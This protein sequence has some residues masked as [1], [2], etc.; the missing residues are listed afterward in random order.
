MVAV[1]NPRLLAIDVQNVET[2]LLPIKFWGKECLSQIYEYRID[3][4]SAHDIDVAL[5]VGKKIKLSVFSS[6]NKEIFQGTIAACVLKTYS[7]QKEGTFIYQLT[8][9]PWLWLLTLQSHCQV[10]QN[11]TVIDIVKSICAHYPETSLD[12]S[13][14][15]KSYPPLEYVVQY[16]ESDYAFIARLLAAY[17]IFFFFISGEEQEVWVLVDNS[18]SLPTL[19]SAVPFQ[20]E[21][22][23]CPHVYS[24]EEQ[25]T[26]FSNTISSQDYNYHEANKVLLATISSVHLSADKPSVNGNQTFEYFYYPGEY[27]TTLEGQK[28]IAQ[29]LHASHALEGEVIKAKSNAVDLRAGTL[30]TLKDTAAHEERYFVMET[31]HHAWDFSYVDS[32][33][34]ETGQGYENHIQ[35]H[36]AFVPFKPLHVSRE[37]EMGVQSAL[38]I[39]TKQNGLSTHG[40][41]EVKVKLCWDNEAS[42]NRSSTCWIRVGQKWAGN[43]YGIQFLPR[44]G[45]EVLV[46]FE[47]GLLSRPVILGCV[48]NKK[49]HVPFSLSD[50]QAISGLKSQ[51]LNVATAYNE[52]SFDD[53]SD[54]NA[55]LTLR[56]QNQYR[57]KVDQNHHGVIGTD[58]IHQVGGVHSMAVG[59]SHTLAAKQGIVLEAGKAS[60]DISPQGI[61]LKGLQVSFN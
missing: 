44:K 46:Y 8:V 33:M 4:A 24:W 23:P 38:V 13:H 61:V 41:G 5:L 1:S 52:L 14:L 12:L 20:N 6:T 31:L 39:D 19:T 45:E 25:Q 30:F 50:T 37:S 51:S 17:G 57:L 47:S 58:L 34:A 59:S 16:N 11:Q 48:H 54:N 7:N 15:T 32:Q 28:K 53:Q 2:P 22:L 21:G 18:A 27:Q 35:C 29:E 9:M 55:L 36:S 56:A 3:V 42:L 26:F 43:A 49:C 10:F 60:V 40:C